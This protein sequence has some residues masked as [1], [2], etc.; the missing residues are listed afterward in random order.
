V[1]HWDRLAAIVWTLLWPIMVF[2][3]LG[4]AMMGDCAEDVIT[5][6]HRGSCVDQKRLV[7]WIIIGLGLAIYA[8]GYWL[9]FR[10]RS[11]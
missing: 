10:K 9:I 5:G 7:G 1:I 2:F 3:A 8:I 6:T 4:F 11:R